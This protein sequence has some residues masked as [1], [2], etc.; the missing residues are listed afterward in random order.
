MKKEILLKEMQMI[1]LSLLKK[2][3]NICVE[4]HLRYF[5]FGGTLLGAVRHK[6][7][8]PWDDDVDIIMPRKDYLRFIKIFKEQQD[9]NI[10]LFSL[11]TNDDY[12]Y[13]YAKVV[14]T[15][16]VLIE[17]NL[18]KIKGYGV[19]IDIFPI[20][21]VA[22][23]DNMEKMFKKLRYLQNLRWRSASTAWYKSNKWY[24]FVPKLLMRMYF[25]II[26]YR[27]PIRKIDEIVSK[28]EYETSTLVG[29]FTTMWERK[30][31]VKKSQLEPARSLQFEDDYFNVP[32]DYHTYLTNL[33]GDYLQLPPEDKRVTHHHYEVYWRSNY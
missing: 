4:N 3:K 12:Y 29:T 18:K 25:G 30:S 6:G 33:Y 19:Y 16:T 2:V 22:K 23:P 26:G 21:G 11:Y 28:N 5:L 17:N 31:I 14:D 1:E 24:G 32:N 8:I 20:D 9:P 27:Y 10:R 15:K 13:P 7:F